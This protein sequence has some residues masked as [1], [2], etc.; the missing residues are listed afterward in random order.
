MAAL[1]SL[2]LKKILNLKGEAGELES[3]CL[4]EG[5]GLFGVWLGEFYY[6]LYKE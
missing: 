1:P 4:P 2:L 3:V 5:P 6:E